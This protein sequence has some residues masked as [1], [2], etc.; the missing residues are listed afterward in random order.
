[1]S[2]RKRNEFLCLTTF[3]SQ[4]ET[5]LGET[6]FGLW[7]ICLFTGDE[8]EIPCSD[9]LCPSENLSSSTCA[10]I[11]AGG[12]FI[13][14]TCVFSG[15]GGLL[16]IVYCAMS[17]GKK[18]RKLILTQ[19][20]LALASLVTGMIGVALGL[21]GTMGIP[22]VPNLEIGDAAIIAIAAVVSNLI[23]AVTLVLAKPYF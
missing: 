3:R 6:T 7:R 1:M 18:L 13:A 20:V 16:C 14:I 5:E 12:A 4:T 2:I 23:G 11:R 22:S 15:I 9:I 17:G 21:A 10:K 19:K 8:N